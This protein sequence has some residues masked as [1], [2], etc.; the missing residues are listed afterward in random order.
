MT[1]ARG[2][3]AVAC[4]GA[5]V[6]AL[7]TSLVAVS[8]PVIA[9]DLRVPA[10]DVSW[11]LTAYLLAVSCLLALAGKAADLLGHKRV[12]L[13]GFGGFVSG[14]AICA[15]AGDLRMLVGGRVVQGIGS[16][17]LMAVGPA[18]VTRS[19]A[20]SRRARALGMQLAATYLGLTLGPSAGG[21]LSAKIGWHAVFVVIASAGAI[22][23]VVASVL[24]PRDE[25]AAKEGMD[26]ASLDLGGAVLFGGGLAA[27]LVALKRIQ[28]GRLRTAVVLG[29]L[30]LATLG[31]FVRHE[32]YREGKT[33]R[34]P[35]L[36]LGLFR[37]PP[38]ALGIL[39]A[40][41]LYTVTFMLAWLLPSYLQRTAGLGPLDAGAFMT[42]QPAA[43]AVVAPISGSISDRWGP[44]IPSVTGM[45]AIAAGLLGISRVA[46][47]HDARLVAALAVVGVG[48]GLF[49]APNSALI[50]GAAP[51]ERQGIAAAMAAT[52]RNVGMTAGI[53]LAASLEH[54]VGFGST[55][56]AAA[57][58]AAIGAILGVVR[59]SPPR[60]AP[61]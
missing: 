15:G 1:S 26:L 47:H 36:P 24:L 2:P 61:R 20:P 38:F 3:M 39:G 52:A 7:S 58:L 35:L 56:V 10:S 41:L 48:A 46:L 12:L 34:S 53:A 59:P 51:R 50:M 14:S 19:V 54:A 27:L 60:P 31:L 29:V 55:L 28:D 18:I 37:K 30:G 16:A 32:G 6:A 45:V 49:V 13:V 42:A 5:F 43:M 57:A 25:R 44:R 11:V 17:M 8:A 33:R 23:G 21:L 40:T 9:R 22:A 4:A